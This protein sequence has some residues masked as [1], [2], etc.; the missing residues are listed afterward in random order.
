MSTPISSNQ[1]QDFQRADEYFQATHEATSATPY[2]H[3]EYQRQLD[4]ARAAL[5]IA[6]EGDAPLAYALE[7][8]FHDSNEPMRYYLST[9]TREELIE[10]ALGATQGPHGITW[11]YTER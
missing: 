10:M 11:Y 9:W 8:L 6:T 3:A 1:A 4:L 5:F 7:W 2:V